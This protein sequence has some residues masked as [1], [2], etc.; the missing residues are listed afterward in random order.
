MSNIFIPAQ[1]KNPWN[2]WTPIFKKG[3]PFPVS[4]SPFG[5]PDSNKVESRSGHPLIYL[6]VQMPHPIA[7]SWKSWTPTYKKGFPFQVASCK[8]AT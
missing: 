7:K 8:P 6:A 1:K 5:D 2:T 4:G 3:S